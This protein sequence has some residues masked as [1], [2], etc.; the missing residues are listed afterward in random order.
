MS[1]KR[2]AGLS[3][4]LAL[5]F[6]GTFVV[7]PMLFFSVQLYDGRL[8]FPYQEA[9]TG[10]MLFVCLFVFLGL[11]IAGMGLQMILEDSK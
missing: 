2:R 11:W 10:V 3:G 7:F 1:Q 6:G 5:A 9:V 8:S 4:P